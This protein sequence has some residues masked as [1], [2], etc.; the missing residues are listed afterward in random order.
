V[1]GGIVSGLITDELRALIGTPWP[2]VEYEVDPS[3]I[4]MWATAVGIDD[5]VFFDEAVARSRGFEAIPAPPGFVGHPR[6]KPG[7]PEPG[8][9]IRGLHPELTRSLNGGTA[10]SYDRPIVAGDVLTATT[11]I[12]ELQEREGSIGRMLLITRETT[13][14]RGPERVAT[15][16]ATV[17]NY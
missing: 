1:S 16:R 14:R 4:R 17:I 7:D 5:P 12:V 2:P 15:M 13:F 10:F 9:P 3:A 6:T 8:P 11:A